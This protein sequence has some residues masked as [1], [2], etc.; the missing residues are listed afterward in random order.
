[1]QA[2]HDIERG[3]YKLVYVDMSDADLYDKVHLVRR[4]FIDDLGDNQA[5]L[6][7]DDESTDIYLLLHKGL[8]VSTARIHRKAL[9]YKIER[10]ATKSSEQKKG[11][12]KVLMEMMH[13]IVYKRYQPGEVVY[14]HSQT[15]AIPF[16]EKV[17]YYAVGEAFIED[18]VIEHYKMYH[19]R[20]KPKEDAQ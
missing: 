6:I 1:M 13:E 17:G 8:P 14:L 3:D 16:Y 20:S 4:T 15:H 18:E 19:S 5:S 7:E 11:Y 10:V 12:G 9:N 2:N